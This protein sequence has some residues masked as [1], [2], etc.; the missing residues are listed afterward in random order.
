MT[1]EIQ[2]PSVDQVSRLYRRVVETS[3]GEQGFLS[4]SNLDY[5]I[6]TVKDDGERLP[7]EKAIVKKAAF[8]LYSIIV[9]H[10]FFERKQEDCL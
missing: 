2:Y 9:I 5:L 7:K 8:L 6:D 10:P 4:K 3:G 1:E